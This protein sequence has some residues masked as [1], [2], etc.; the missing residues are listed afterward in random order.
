MNF[1]LIEVHLKYIVNKKILYFIFI[2]I[3]ITT[4]IFTINTRFTV[5]DGYLKMNAKY[6]YES[7]IKESMSYYYLIVSLFAIFLPSITL[8][9]EDSSYD[10]Y[11]LTSEN[12]LQIINTKLL[13]SFIII[14]YYSV[15]ILI[16]L[17]IIPFTLVDYMI[18]EFAAIKF[19]AVAILYAI[20]YNLAVSLILL[21][22]NNIF[23]LFILLVIFLILKIN[24]DEIVYLDKIP[25]Y[26]KVIQIFMPILSIYDKENFVAFVTIPYIVTIIFIVLLFVEVTYMYK[27]NR[28]NWVNNAH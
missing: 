13:A 23:G 9:S 19:A 3:I 14:V 2:S 10:Q 11:L 16:L 7:Y 18:V 27:Q 5:N 12:K 4:V 22:F 8:I 24:V 1:K 25:T 20:Y 17:Y 21:K 6:M 26:S 15:I 28:F